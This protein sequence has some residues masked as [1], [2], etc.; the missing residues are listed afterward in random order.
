MEATKTIT[1]QQY[2]QLLGLQA[3]GTKHASLM[4][5]CETEMASIIGSRDNGMD[6]ASETLYADRSIDWYLEANNVK[7]EE[8]AHAPGKLHNE[9]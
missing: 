1:K 9:G 2:L 5:E 8:E 6:G 4:Q 3:L 7:V